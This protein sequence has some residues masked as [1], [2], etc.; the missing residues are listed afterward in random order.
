MVELFKDAGDLFLDLIIESAEL[1]ADEDR[2][3]KAQSA[4]AGTQIKEKLK[5]AKNLLP[6]SMTAGGL[7]PLARMYDSFSGN[8]HAR[9]DTE[10]LRLSRNLKQ[11]FDFVF[12]NIAETLHKAKEMR[13]HLTAPMA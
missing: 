7:N 11:H 4:K 13:S 2:K 12:E 5:Q 9:N 10:C 3:K 6:P 8:V 1:E